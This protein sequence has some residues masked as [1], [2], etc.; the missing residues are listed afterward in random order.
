M[1]GHNNVC[2]ASQFN[3]KQVIVSGMHWDYPIRRLLD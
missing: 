2:V 1:V 3:P